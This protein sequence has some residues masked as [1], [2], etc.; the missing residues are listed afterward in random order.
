MEPLTILGI[1]LLK[2]L[3]DYV[4]KDTPNYESAS[5]QKANQNRQNDRCIVCGSKTSSKG[6]QYCSKHLPR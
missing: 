4:F 2:K 5:G 3:G 6:I 1:V